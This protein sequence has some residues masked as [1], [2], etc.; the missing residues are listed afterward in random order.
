MEVFKRNYPDSGVILCDTAADVADGSDAIVL[1]TEWP[2]Y[3]DL[4]W[5]AL[6]PTMQS[7]IVLDGRNIL[8]RSRLEG[9]GFRYLS[10]AG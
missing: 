3:R 1:V 5:N 4:D 6:A 2:E 7:P 10:L 8:D 9:A